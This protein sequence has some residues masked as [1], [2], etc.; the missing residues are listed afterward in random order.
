M[1]ANPLP[2]A[3]IPTTYR[4]THFRSKLEAQW[5]RTFDLL[6]VTW[7]Y[8]PEGRATKFGCYLPDFYLPAMKGGT[9]L[10]VKPYDLRG[11]EE[12][13][14]VEF[15]LQR[16]QRLVT[17]FGLR[18]PF[19]GAGDDRAGAGLA[20]FPSG[21]IDYGYHLTVCAVCGEAGLEFE[22]RGARACADRKRCYGRLDADKAVN[23]DDFRL[24][25][26]VADARAYF[27]G[28]RPSR[29]SRTLTDDRVLALAEA[30]R[31]A[32][33]N[34]GGVSGWLQKQRL[35]PGDYEAVLQA[36]GRITE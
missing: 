22:G 16:K 8:E 36:W 28:A 18:D 35:A 4:G 15:V 5:A 2:P 24:L 31:D 11:L 30:A 27:S 33:R 21:D 25:A 10:E 29:S 12:P 23:T 32:E 20:I 3:P 7:E 14:W 26:A 34:P 9:W 19:E 13:R 1:A 17:V 6:H